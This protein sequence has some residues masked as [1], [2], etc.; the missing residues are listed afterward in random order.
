MAGGITLKQC[1]K[2][3]KPIC[4]KS[5]YCVRCWLDEVQQLKSEG[6]TYV[7]IKALMNA[8]YKNL[9]FE[10]KYGEKM[11]EE[12]CPFCEMELSRGK[13][14]SCGVCVSCEGLSDG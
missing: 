6:F 3:N 12:R 7:E 14:M 9:A 5:N 11:I 8:T 4:L 2:C 1:K 13:C 10:A